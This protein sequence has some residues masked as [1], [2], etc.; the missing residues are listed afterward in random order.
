[1]WKVGPPQSFEKTCS[2]GPQLLTA[3]GPM[4]N[5]S[6]YGQVCHVS[7]RPPEEETQCLSVLK[8]I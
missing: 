2:V 4:S 1:M 7:E 3:D 8:S 6:G 5:V